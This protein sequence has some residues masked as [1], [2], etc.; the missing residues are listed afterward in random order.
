MFNHLILN[1]LFTPLQYDFIPSYSSIDQILTLIYDSNP[2]ADLRG[3]FLD[4]FKAFNK[5]W[6]KVL[7][8]N[9]KTYGVKG[10]LLSLL[11]CYLSNREH[12][13]QRVV[14]NR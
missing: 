1:K 14:L 5:V 10:E 2:P 3:V 11:A 8:F 9:L 6:R 13:E 4:I 12:R 7:L